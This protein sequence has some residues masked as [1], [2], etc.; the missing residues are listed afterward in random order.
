MQPDIVYINA[1]AATN[2]TTDAKTKD[3]KNKPSSSSSP[4]L[5][6]ES[7]KPLPF[8]VPNGTMAEGAFTDLF[9]NSKIK[10]IYLDAANT[11]TLGQ[12]L[13]ALDGIDHVICWAPEAPPMSFHSMYFAHILFACLE[14]QALIIPEAYAIASHLTRTFCGRVEVESGKVTEP[15][16]PRLIS[17]VP[18]FLP[19]SAS[20][21]PYVHK[22]ENGTSKIH[23]HAGTSTNNAASGAGPSN[24]NTNFFKLDGAL[25]VN[26]SRLRLCAP[27]AELRMMLTGLYDV[28]NAHCMAHL[29]ESFRAVLVGEVRSLVLVAMTPCTAPPAYLPT[30]ST[31]VQCE[32]RTAT[33]ITF[34]VMMG[35]PADAF[36]V[37]SLVQHALRQTIT[38][39]AQALQLKLPPPG[40]ML[41][42]I[43]THPAV[44]GGAYCIEIMALTSTWAV[45]L[46]KKMSRNAQSRTLV[47]LGVAAV[48]NHPTTA[49]SKF[50]GNRFMA[51]ATENDS[52]KVEKLLKNEEPAVM[53]GSVQKKPRVAPPMPVTAADAAAATAAVFAAAAAAQRAGAGGQQPGNTSGAGVAKTPALEGVAPRPPSAVVGSRPPSGIGVAPLAPMAFPAPGPSAIPRIVSAPANNTNTNTGNTTVPSRAP[54]G[55]CTEEV[56]LSDLVNFLKNQLKRSIDPATFPEIILNGSKLD[57]FTLY[58]EVCRRGGYEAANRIDWKSGVFPWM[59]NFSAGHKLTAIGNMLKH[60]YQSLLLEYEKQ[61]PGDVRKDGCVSCGDSGA[62]GDGMCVVCRGGGSGRSSAAGVAVGDAVMGPGGSAAVAPMDLS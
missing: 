19:T 36:K 20:I 13:F 47:S 6:S 51:I 52:T 46:I 10:L 5:A 23:V 4:L 48:S 1:G 38:A 59:K 7:L 8:T 16:L 30:G 24:F 43:K 22:E 50:D 41:P 61:H 53:P 37:H 42:E 15:N 27:H 26:Y 49:F 25:G 9:A 28:L 12:K 39:D 17:L 32:V 35:G 58:R 54:I 34:T 2:T 56:F 29:C 60:H 33:G 57:V 18:G 62:G 21:P 14:N 45:Q 40:A 44:A 3:D 55:T 11:L 31:A